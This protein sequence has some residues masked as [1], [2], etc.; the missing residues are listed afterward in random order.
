M[1]VL[2]IVNVSF[3]Y[4]SIKALDNVSFK[5]D[6]GE[7]VTLLGPNGSGKTTLLRCICGLLRKF[8]GKII[9]MDKDVNKYNRLELAKIIGYVPQLNEKAFPLTVYEWILLGR[10]PYM[11][12]TPKKRDHEIVEK[13]INTLGIDH[14]KF[15]KV[16]ELS[17]G[18]WRIVELARALAQEPKALLLDEP[19][20]HLDFKNQILVL[21]LLRKLVKNHEIVIL[22]TTHDINQALW[23]SDKIVLLKNGKIIF[24][25]KT[26]TL[27]PA[28]I[29]EAYDMDIELIKVKDKVIAIPK[30]I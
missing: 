1:V 16:T 15:R 29:K 6:Y 28:I 2:E 27:N 19:T 30:T 3:R 8:L 22:M 21:N 7:L 23:F 12:F 9:I 4:D 26:N 25:G 10:K 14:L 20:N 24:C 18:E 5:I 11:G 13:V 17:G